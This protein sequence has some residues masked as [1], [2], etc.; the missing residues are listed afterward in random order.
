MRRQQEYIQQYAGANLVVALAL[1]TGARPQFF[2]KSH[3]HQAQRQHDTER[4]LRSKAQKQQREIEK[5]SIQKQ[6]VQKG[7][8]RDTG[9]GGEHYDRVIQQA[10]NGDEVWYE[11]DG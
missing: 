9:S 4:H 2:T 7:R 5:S 8:R 10:D 11:V 3:R 6:R 1:P